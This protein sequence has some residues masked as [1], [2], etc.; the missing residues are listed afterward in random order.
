MFDKITSTYTAYTAND[1]TDSSQDFSIDYY[2]GWLCAVLGNEYVITANT[3]T[4]LSFANALASLETYT[5]EFVTRNFLTVLESDLQDVVKFPQNLLTSKFKATQ[6]HLTAKIKAYF[7]NL[8]LV[9]DDIDPMTLILNLREIQLPFA[10]YMLA[11]IYGDTMLVAEDINAFKEQKYRKK[12]N[13]LIDDALSMLSVDTD[14]DG[15][16]SNSDYGSSKGKGFI[17]SR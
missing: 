4:S 5:I 6:E 17:L 15:E 13:E 9:Y 16:L 10:Y 2:K 1:I 11:E 14:E 8:Y 12:Y 7:K 3:E